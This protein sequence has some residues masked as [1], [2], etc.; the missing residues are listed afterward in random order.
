[1]ADYRAAEAAL[2]DQ[3]K[4]LRAMREAQEAN[5]RPLDEGAGNGP[6]KK[7]ARRRRVAQ[8]KK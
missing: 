3:T 6:V 4:K 8:T 5:S 2:R 1:M 7:V